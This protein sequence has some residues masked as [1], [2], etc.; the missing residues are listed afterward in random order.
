MIEINLKKPRNYGIPYMGSKSKILKHIADIFPACDNFYDLFGGGFSVTHYLLMHRPNDFK[1]FHFNEIRPGVC[2]LIKKAIAGGFGYQNY[3][4]PWVSREEFHA[5]KEMDPLVKLLWSFGNN[6]RC[7]LFGDIAEYKR[8]LH[9]CVVFGEF[10][11]VAKEVCGF[12]KW[13]EECADIKARRLFIQ[14]RV[15]ELNPNKRAGELQQLERLERLHLYSGDYREVPITENSVVYCDIPYK[16]T[17]EYDKNKH[18]NHD[19]FFDWAANCKHPVF[20]SEYNIDDD[21]FTLLK[22]VETRS[23]L[24]ATNNGCKKIERVY[25]NEA[26]LAGV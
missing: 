20:I 24:S 10:D 6:G 21:R 5:K 26:A 4:M 11:D 23:T 22:E 17:G 9:Q 13:P 2:D 18:F 12:N 14:R 3:K 7:Y 1:K 25:C 15:R 16:G 8:S 19:E